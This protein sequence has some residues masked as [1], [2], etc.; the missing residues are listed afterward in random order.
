MAKILN[1]KLENNAIFKQKE[2]IAQSTLN[3]NQREENV[4]DVYKIAK[5]KAIENKKILLIDDIFTTGSTANECAKTLKIAGAK[6]IDVFT[7][8]KD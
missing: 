2:N 5:N 1:I 4:I 8:A 6:K 3:K 7:I